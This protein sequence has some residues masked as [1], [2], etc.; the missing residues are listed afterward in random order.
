MKLGLQ[1]IDLYYGT[2]YVSDAYFNGVKVWTRYAD[3]RDY[4]ASELATPAQNS[5]AVEA[6]LAVN[7][8]VYFGDTGEEYT[9]LKPIRPQS[10]ARLK[11]YSTLKLIDTSI[12]VLAA[13]VN[14]GE[15]DV[16]LV[17]ASDFH[18]NQ[19]VVIYDDNSWNTILRGFP[20]WR[21]WGA[22]ITNKVGNT[23]T[24][25]KTFSSFTTLN[26]Q[27]KYEVS[28]NAKCY[29]S[30]GNIICEDK[31][32]ITIEGAGIIDNNRAGQHYSSPAGVGGGVENWECANAVLFFNCSNCTIRDVTINYGNIHGLGIHGL[33]LG[34]SSYSWCYDISVINIK[35]NYCQQK[36]IE[37]RYLIGAYFK[38]NQTDN[39]YTED[40]LMFYTRANNIV[41]DGH[42]CS[43]NLRSGFAWS[44]NCV[45]LIA[46]NIEALGGNGVGIRS[47]SKNAVFNDCESVGD[48]VVV[49]GEYDCENIEF[50]NLIIRNTTK[51]Y[52]L[53]LRRDVKD[54]RFNNLQIIDCNGIGIAARLDGGAGYPT[55]VV[56]TNGGLINHTGTPTSIEVGS[57]V[58][59]TNFTGV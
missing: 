50:N 42:K 46:N 27:V 9:F 7:D 49:T 48:L 21:S 19:T 29:H 25:D 8:Y 44:A 17:D 41:I 53:D 38:N 45:G 18:I 13:D 36:G 14:A 31:E 58:T 30:Q 28:A 11:I 35:T 32:N 2:Q 55:E 5:A 24:L 1:D 15:F 22:R 40:G 37:V 43:G 51:T 4:G 39:S 33:S 57:D 34:G 52:I 26:G 59:F 10:G 16:T 3:I 54:I 23:I 56:F 47:S 20:L 12:G 6:A